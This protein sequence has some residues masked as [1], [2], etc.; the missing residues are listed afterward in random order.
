MEKS[1]PASEE[2][3]RWAGG[4]KVADEKVNSPAGGSK[5]VNSKLFS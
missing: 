4:I 3:T 2:R 1:Q 5:L